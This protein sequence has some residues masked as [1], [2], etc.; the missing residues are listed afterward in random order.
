MGTIYTRRLAK[1]IFMVLI[2][3]ALI[4]PVLGYPADPDNAALYYYQA[5][6]LY[7]RP[8]DTTQH[9]LVD[10]AKA[11]IAPNE[12]IRDYVD[13]CHN[14]IYYAMVAADMQ[15][16]NWGLMYSDGFSALFPHLAQT[17]H[18]LWTILADA[19][20][21]AA[22]GAYRQA[23]ERCLAA[24]KLAQHVG[25]ETIISFLVSASISQIA[26]SC[27]RDIL[28]ALPQ[29]LE[30]L[31]WLQNQL[32]SLTHRAPSTQ[33]T[34]EAEREIA[35]ANISVEGIKVLAEQFGPEQ[36]GQMLEHL[37]Q[38]DEQF[39]AANRDYYA[40]HTAAIQTTVASPMTYESKFR[41]LKELDEK[42]RKDMA[43][44]N[45][46]TLTAAIAPAMWK[47][48][49]RE[50]TSRTQS[51][52][53]RAAIDIYIIKAETG[54]LPDALPIGLPKD[55]FSGEDFAYEK[56]DD[57]FVLRCQGRDLEKDTVHEYQ[58]K[59]AW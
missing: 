59:I 9:M 54:R 57:G 16:C 49:N 46:A 2:L 21:L 47:V 37:G 19:R 22:D 15:Q 53:T 31:K 40:Q 13:G 51:N 10:V 43:E 5:F 56:T 1:P 44:D 17:R 8:D 33:A 6:L 20:I 38:V 23:L 7:E 42:P 18:L 52:A 55:L 12:E 14:A 45:S 34:M 11:K 30:T 25:D 32:V 39:L 58:F 28:G 48:C 29:E 24:R 27:L 4:S 3:L 36:G 35:M 26:N 50:V 41:K